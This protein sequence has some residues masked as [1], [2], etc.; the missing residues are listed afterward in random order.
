M[1]IKQAFKHSRI[2]YVYVRTL[3]IHSEQLHMCI[4]MVVNFIDCY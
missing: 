4:I 1:C 2:A 3:C